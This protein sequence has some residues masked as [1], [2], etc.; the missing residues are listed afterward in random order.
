MKGWVLAGSLLFLLAAGCLGPEEGQPTWEQIAKSV[1]DGGAPA[2]NTSGTNATAGHGTSGNSSGTTPGPDN[3]SSGGNEG[4]PAPQCGN[5]QM[6][7]VP[8]FN[9][10]LTTC[11]AGCGTLQPEVKDMCTNSCYMKA[12]NSTGNAAYCMS[13]TIP[14]LMGRCYSIAAIAKKDVCICSLAKDPRQK[15]ECELLYEAP[16]R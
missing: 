12:V 6:P 5:V 1:A 15:T 8:S 3:A 10:N 2:N 14:H 4:G 9:A 13:L 11:H 16:V 7:S